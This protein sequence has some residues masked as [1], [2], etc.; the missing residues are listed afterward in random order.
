MAD[1]SKGLKALKD[2]DYA[3]AMREWQHLAEQG[4]A[5]AQNNMGAIYAN[6]WGVPQDYNQALKWTKLAAEQGQAGA[7][8]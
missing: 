7:Q 1:F 2:G 5:I 8:G 3:T 6:G 4:H